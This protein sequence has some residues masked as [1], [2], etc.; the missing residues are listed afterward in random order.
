MG[1]QE[2]QRLSTLHAPTFFKHLASSSDRQYP[3]PVKLKRL[4]LKINSKKGEPE[5]GRACFLGCSP[6]YSV[7]WPGTSLQNPDRLGSYMWLIFLILG[8]QS[9]KTRSETPTLWHCG[10]PLLPLARATQHKWVPS[11]LWSLQSFWCVCSELSFQLVFQA[12]IKIMD[13]LLWSLECDAQNFGACH[14]N[15]SSFELSVYCVPAP[16]FIL[17]HSHNNPVRLVLLLSPLYYIFDKTETVC[18][19]KIYMLKV[20]Q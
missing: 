11:G 7:S 3:F 4:T 1:P 16:K 2:I 20:P 15:S 14:I 17:F 19:R 5:E 9:E 6:V 12:Q 18:S 8:F 10:V 13:I